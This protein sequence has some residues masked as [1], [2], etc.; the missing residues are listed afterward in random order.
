MTQNNP[1]DLRLKHP[2]HLNLKHLKHL[3]LKHHLKHKFPRK[4]QSPRLPKS[5]LLVFCV[6]VKFFRSSFSGSFDLDFG[7][8]NLWLGLF[9]G[10]W[11]VDGLHGALKE[12]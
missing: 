3:H 10:L 1:E 4:A 5:R 12:L 11:A 2:K 7:S 6:Q 9:I 8:P